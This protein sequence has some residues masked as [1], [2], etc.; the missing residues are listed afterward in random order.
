[1]ISKAFKNPPMIAS[2]EAEPELPIPDNIKEM[3]IDTYSL[4]F[5]LIIYLYPSIVS[6]LL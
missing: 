5:F 4:A 1:M 2:F 3:N 6:I